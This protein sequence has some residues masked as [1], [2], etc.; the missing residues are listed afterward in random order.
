MLPADLKDRFITR[1]TPRRRRFAVV[2]LVLFT[3][4]SLFGFFALP[5]IIASEAEKFVREQLELEL[6]IKDVEFNPWRL[7][8][9]LDG[10]AV[11]DPEN[12]G[13]AL[14]AARSIYVNAELWSS[15]WIRGASLCELDLLAPY[16][17]ARILQDGDIN[18]MKLV[19]PD[20]EE[21]SSG[22]THWRI[23]QLG[24][25]QGRVDFRD[26]TRP[27]P[28]SA[29][30]S[31]LNLSLADLSSRPDKDGGYT[32]HAETGEGEALDWK[33]T[34]ALKPVR[35]EGELRISGLKATTPWRYLQDEL[36]VVVENGLIGI[37]GHYRLVA[38]EEVTFTLQDGR[39]TVDDLAVS[40]R[41]PRPL[42]VT[43]EQMDLKGVSAAWPAQSGSFDTLRLAGFQ[44]ADKTTGQ[45]FN[46]FAELLLEKG[47]YLPDGERVELSSLGLSTLVLED[48]S[49]SL[50]LIALPRLTLKSLQASLA[51]QQA[52]VGQVILEKGDLS[53]RRDKDSRLNWETRLDEL[54]RRLEAFSAPVA[55]TPATR[56]ADT[57]R[58]AAEKPWDTTLGELDLI[59]FRV[60]FVDRVPPESLSTSLENI[61]LR[62]FPRQPGEKQHRLDGRMEIGTGGTLSLKGGFQEQPLTANVDLQLQGLKLPPFAPWAADVARFALEKGTLDVNGRFNFQ[63]AKTSRAD[64]AGNVVIQDFAAN[65]LELD[66]RFLAWRRLAI[67]GVN[68][69]MEPGR[70]AIREIQADRPFIR[71]I[72]G[73]DQSL[74]LSHVVVAPENTD[75]SSA[76]TASSPASP[77]AAKATENRKAP[78][79]VYPL[80]IDRIRM[81]DG[82]MLF[83]DLT[84]RPQF[85]TGIQSLEGDIRGLS[86]QPDSRATITLKGRVDEYG[87]ADINGTLNPLAGD[88]FTDVSVKFSNVEL[89]TLTPYSSKFA[90][91]RIDKGKL[92]LDL[93]YKI[94]QRQLKASNK[95]VLNQ[96]MLGDKVASPDATSLPLKL[97]VAILKD[98][99]GVI[100]IDLPITGS[101]DDPK[102]KIGPLVWKT[103]V[104]LLTRA[105]TA[106]FSLIAGMVGGGD[107]MDSLNFTAGASTLPTDE[108][109]KLDALAKALAQRPAL[110]VEIRGAFDPDADAKAIRTA[111]FD[112]AYQK[113]LAEGGTPR[114]VLE[115]LFKAKLGSE[116]LAQ[117]RTLSLKPATSQADT[118]SELKLA[119]DAYETHLRNELIARETVLEGDL[120]QLA[121]DRARVVR[122]QLVET[123]KV[124]ES[125]VFVLEPVTTKATGNSVVMKV[126]LTAS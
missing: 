54:T 81:S 26:D 42:L 31:P 47:R 41:G 28:F 123:N 100:D 57:S 58:P 121:L 99:D 44:L 74:N 84:L 60:G 92:S 16:I 78:E 51:T 65:D 56:N 115:E 111:K 32:L 45:A 80:R 94:N 22:E 102:F 15:L 34:V 96:L 69:Q 39:I 64:F 90:G 17:N 75:S 120:R 6:V 117:Q 126:S 113:R 37:S 66:E 53:V 55:A 101:L 50:P 25:H 125:R 2:F 95:V 89:T 5:G 46:H 21:E 91:Y 18:L 108:L 36:P 11:N 33:G 35:S 83:A 38:D 71:V 86:S 98:K 79:P 103:F 43:L 13:E 104:N 119:I 20:D 87:K 122:N 114:K 8:L 82:S 70:L 48:G 110:A 27:T 97:A 10:I 72:V 107:N 29:V 40:Q 63:Q 67:Q 76:D 109:A 30:F 118:R 61:N 88:L 1:M 7:A 93:N 14:V 85:A 62:L 124:E 9:R 12:G 77:S 105:A 23:G 73:E 68:W 24:I 4:Y 59:G 19:P 3:I 112:Q 116:A 52:H 106:P 49:E